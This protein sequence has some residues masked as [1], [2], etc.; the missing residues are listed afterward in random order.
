MSGSALHD[1]KPSF[2]STSLNL[3][4]HLT[5]LDLRPYNA[6]YMRSRCSASALNSGPALI[7]TF[8]DVNASRY[9][10]PMSVPHTFNP[11]SSAKKRRI[12][13]PCKDTTLEYTLPSGISVRC[14]SATSLAL[15]LPSCL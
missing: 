11:L 12:H 7:Q 1:V 15:C 3:S 13:N 5:P 2:L 8:S 6:L 14:P 4:C 10:L 9:A